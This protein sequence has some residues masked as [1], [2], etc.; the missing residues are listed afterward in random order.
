VY[1]SSVHGVDVVCMLLILKVWL[2]DMDSN[3]D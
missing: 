3:H 2:P 1:R